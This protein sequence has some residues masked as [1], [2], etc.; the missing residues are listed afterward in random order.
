ML[1]FIEFG[2]S[3]GLGH[4]VAVVGAAPTGFT[5]LEILT[6]Q[7]VSDTHPKRRWPTPLSDMSITLIRRAAARR[8]HNETYQQDHVLEDVDTDD[9]SDEGEF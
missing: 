1:P 2:V 4:G 8:T 7:V 5:G 6:G 3:T 9:W